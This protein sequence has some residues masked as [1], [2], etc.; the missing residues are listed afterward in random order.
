MHVLLKYCICINF[1]CEW[2]LKK[3][4]KMLRP[5]ADVN[6]AESSGGSVKTASHSSL[7]SKGVRIIHFALQIA[8]VWRN[9]MMLPCLK[10]K[11]KWS[12]VCMCWEASDCTKGFG[13]PACTGLPQRFSPSRNKTFPLSPG[14]SMWARGWTEQKCRNQWRRHRAKVAFESKPMT[15][16]SNT[17]LPHILKPTA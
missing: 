3:K 2:K 14:S 12:F 15:L 9:Y 8:A 5:D 11:T 1:L 16:Q 10:A 13:F 6:M 17:L 4:K 7:T